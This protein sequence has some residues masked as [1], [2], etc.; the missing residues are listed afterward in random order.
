[1]A[2]VRR[3][4]QQSLRRHFGSLRNA[5]TTNSSAQRRPDV[6]AHGKKL[7]QFAYTFKNGTEE[8]CDFDLQTYLVQ[9]CKAED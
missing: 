6:F 3:A 1:M 2:E 5:K 8:T 4:G 9:R 7:G